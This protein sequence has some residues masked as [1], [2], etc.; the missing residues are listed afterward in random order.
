MPADLLAPP[1]TDDPAAGTVLAPA[2]PAP[3]S[4]TPIASRLADVI[5]GLEAGIVAVGAAAAAAPL[6]EP[7]A[8]ADATAAAALL[9]PFAGLG[10]AGS[11]VLAAAGTVPLEVTIAASAAATAMLAD[12]DRIMATSG[13]GDAAGPGGGGP[14]GG[15]VPSR[16]DRLAALTELPS[17]LDAF[18]RITRRIAGDAVV[19]VIANASDIGIGI[20][21]E[22]RAPDAETLEAWISRMA[23]VRR[24]L[25]AFDDL[26]LFIEATGGAP[27]G[28]QVA[29]LPL[30]TGESWFGGELAARDAVAGAN[31]LRAWVRP[32]GPRVHVVAVGDRAAVVAAQISALVID[33]VVEV[34][35]G[36][37][38]TT[39]LG[40]HYDAPNARPPQSLLLAVHPDPARPWTWDL[41]DEIAGEALALA[42]IRAVD[43]DD[44]AP[45][46][47]DEYIPLTYLR[48]GVDGTAPL[49]QL[50]AGAAWGQLMVNATRFLQRDV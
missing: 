32:A 21:D 9:D 11:V 30:V 25:A 33:E 34:L 15:P 2:P 19:P 8:V 41:L 5:E 36:P 42:R 4:L 45:T 16:R 31:E 17:A 22:V 27:D 40:L 29:H 50:T 35:P 47:I 48:D 28:L 13:G 26:R 24:G 6:P 14:G 18:V 49:S 12:V 38:V 39:G 10:I 46:A 44:L 37:S 3:A 7:G 43:V 23:R 1:Q 20:L